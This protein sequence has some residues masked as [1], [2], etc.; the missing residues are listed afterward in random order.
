MNSTMIEEEF[1]FKFDSMGRPT[2]FHGKKKNGCSFQNL[3]KNPPW[4]KIILPISYLAIAIT[5]LQTSNKINTK[6]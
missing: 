1:S 2:D 3:K 6:R 4:Y 5:Y